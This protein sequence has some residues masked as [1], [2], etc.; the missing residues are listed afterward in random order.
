MGIVPD[1]FT[2]YDGSFKR[3]FLDFHLLYPSFK[4]IT[5][6]TYT[7]FVVSLSTVSS[8]GPFFVKSFIKKEKLQVFPTVSPLRF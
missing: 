8:F 2:I 5:D 4:A 3:F 1:V 6:L 7:A